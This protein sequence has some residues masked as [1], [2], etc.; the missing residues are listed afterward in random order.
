MATVLPGRPIE[1][2]EGAV[3]EGENLSVPAEEVQRRLRRPLR[4]AGLLLGIAAVLAAWSWFEWRQDEVLRVGGVR[5][6]AELVDIDYRRRRPDALEVRY[7]VAGTT[8]QVEVPGD[9]DGREPG[10]RIEI[11]Y[12]PD[13]PGHAR[14]VEGW[15]PAYEFLLLVAAV[16]ALATPALWFYDRHQVR[17]TVAAL[18]S[19]DGETM[20]AVPHRRWTW[21]RRG[22]Q[23]LAALSSSEADGDPAFVVELEP[24]AARHLERGPAQ[25]HGDLRPG[26]RVVLRQ[27][28]R[29]IWPVGKVRDELPSRA[30]PVG[31][32]G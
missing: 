32:S 28:E 9:V 10:D 4:R 23:H 5:A 12:D 27:G 26:G 17:Q 20:W 29:T 21:A 16:L 24:R 11:A 19:G 3:V 31:T 18:E 8:Y 14:P 22:Y 15:A 7:Q 25:V 6:D 30:K 2:S 1:G 13:D